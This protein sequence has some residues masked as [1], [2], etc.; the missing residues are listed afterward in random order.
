MGFEL[1]VGWTPEEPAP[2]AL[3]DNP[4]CAAPLMPAT[5]WAIAALAA[6]DPTRSGPPPAVRTYLAC[7]DACLA[8]LRTEV[9]GA[10]SAPVRYGAYWRAIG[11]LTA[12]EPT[13]ADRAGQV[14]A[15][16]PP[17]PAPDAETRL[18]LATEQ[19]SA[20]RDVATLSIRLGG[21]EPGLDEEQRAAMAA[22]DA[23]V[24]DHQRRC[25]R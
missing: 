20:V 18:A 17:D 23:I 15:P 1:V 16:R 13:E 10:W 8:G 19:A 25:G 6:P 24:R 14:C 7:G 21:E 2:I 22:A 9:G 12:E 4:A 5:G 11:P 3:C